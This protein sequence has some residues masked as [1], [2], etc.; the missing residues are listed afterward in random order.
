MNVKIIASLLIIIIVFT[1]L[2][3]VARELTRDEMGQ[4]LK[5]NLRRYKDRKEK[6]ERE[7]TV[8]KVAFGFIN[9]IL[10]TTLFSK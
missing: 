1:S 9:L 7:E 6:E 8:K 5:G 4:E 2:S 3:V 10:F